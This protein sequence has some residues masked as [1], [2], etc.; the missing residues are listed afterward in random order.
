MDRSDRLAGNV[1]AKKQPGRA[2]SRRTSEADRRTLSFHRRS[3][4]ATR[5]RSPVRRRFRMAGDR[6]KEYRVGRRFPAPGGPGPWGGVRRMDAP[7][8]PAGR[9]GLPAGMLGLIGLVIAVEMGLGRSHRFDND[10]AESW[11]VKASAARRDAPGCDV[12]GFGDSLIEFGLLPAILEE[13]LGG[14]AYNL[15]T[16]AGSPSSSYFLLKQALDAGARPR[17]VV[18]DFSPHQVVRNPGH[19]LIRRRAW[20]ELATLGEAIDLWRTLRDGDLFGSI[21]LGKVFRSVKARPEIR[22]AIVTDVKGRFRSVDEALLAPVT[23]RNLRLNRGAYVM[24]ASRPTGRPVAGQRRLHLPRPRPGPDR[25]RRAVPPG[26][27]RR[28]ASRS[29]GSCCRSARRCRRSPTPRAPTPGT[30]T[31]S[32]DSSERQFPDLVVARR[33]PDPRLRPGSVHGPDPPRRQGGRGP[34][35]R[36]GRPD[37]R[38]PDPG[39]TSR[40]VALAPYRDRPPTR[41]L[42]DVAETRLAFSKAW[43]DSQPKMR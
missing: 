11:R 33:P 21:V 14:K 34:D 4:T 6:P 28:E 1:D 3:A 12:L 23:Y 18:V 26:W 31:W 39:P 29:T 38:A 17:A 36:A 41:H 30:A 7:T 20:P 8:R 15:A 42:E 9:T 13:R 37:A 5:S 2:D 40:H 32:G 16:H 22:S 43:T 35:Q 10:M 24:P 19:E 27:P 25:L